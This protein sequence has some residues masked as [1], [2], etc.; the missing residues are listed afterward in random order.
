MIH[1]D[2]SADASGQGGYFA[3]GMWEYRKTLVAPT[4]WR[5]RRVTLEFEGVYRDAMVYVN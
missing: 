4:D 5:D 2:R 3:G 1:T